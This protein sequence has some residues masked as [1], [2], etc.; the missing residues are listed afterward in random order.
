MFT[1]FSP[2]NAKNIPNLFDVNKIN[3]ED[4]KQYK[5][6]KV[7]DDNIE[8][9]KTKLNEATKLRSIYIHKS[10]NLKKEYETL[11]N[12]YKLQIDE[13]DK[14]IKE[15]NNEI[16]KSKKKINYIEDIQQLFRNSYE[17]KPYIDVFIK[18]YNELSKNENII[19]K[20]VKNEVK[21][22]YVMLIESNN[23][24]ELEQMKLNLLKNMF[25]YINQ[26]IKN[27]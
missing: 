2:Y 13:L 19:I 4:S 26:F 23:L 11:I 16:E 1:L 3:S 18:L 27:E 25:D 21:N 5:S 20:I 15:Y 10:E 7:Y 14:L 9:I 6:S 22:E 12:K 24:N 17:Y 8:I